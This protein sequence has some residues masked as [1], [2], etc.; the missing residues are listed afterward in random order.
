MLVGLSGICG[1]LSYYSKV[2]GT[3]PQ[4]QILCQLI[5]PNYS[6]KVPVIQVG[7]MD[8]IPPNEAFNHLFLPAFSKQKSSYFMAMSLRRKIDASFNARMAYVLPA[9]PHLEVL[10]PPPSRNVKQWA[11][12]QIVP[13]LRLLVSRETGF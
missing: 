2:P 5:Y 11:P 3:V 8:R 12:F 6:P 13:F 9:T 10:S 7:L 4:V 1:S